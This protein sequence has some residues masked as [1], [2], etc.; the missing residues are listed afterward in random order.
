M[1]RE[2]P[3]LCVNG[4]PLGEKIE[5]AIVW[6]LGPEN[7]GREYEVVIRSGRSLREKWPKLV[8]AARRRRNEPGNFEELDRWIASAT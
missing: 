8:A 1:P 2:I 6:A 3:E 4:E 5:V 7:L